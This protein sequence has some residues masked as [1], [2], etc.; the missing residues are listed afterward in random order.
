MVFTQP[1]KV[2][3]LCSKSFCILCEWSVFYERG[4]DLCRFDHVVRVFDFFLA[5]HPLMPVY[6]T[7]ALLIHLR[8]GI[9]SCECD[10]AAIHTFIQNIPGNLNVTL[11]FANAKSIFEQVPPHKLFPRSTYI[12]PSDS[13]FLVNHPSELLQ[14]LEP[15][16]FYRDHASGPYKLFVYFR[17]M[18]RRHRNV[19][20]AIG[21]P[22]F[23]GV[24]CYVV[25]RMIGTEIR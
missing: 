9:L 1:G 21:I 7:C 13:P 22:V 18:L 4:C 8:K 16:Y 10:I 23:A 6:T 15:Y 24:L 11:C 5:S 19:V 14:R 20:A 25:T 17:R 2:Q 3:K 12:F